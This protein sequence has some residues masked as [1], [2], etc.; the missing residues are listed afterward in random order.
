MLPVM[1]IG[2]AVATVVVQQ[3]T[4][5][6]PTKT[7]VTTPRLST[8]DSDNPGTANP[9]PIPAASFNYSYWM[10]LF[11]TITNI[12]DATLLNN[13]KFYSDGTIGWTLGS[14][15]ELRMGARDSGDFGLPGASYEQATG[16][17]GTSG[18]DLEASHTYYSGQTNKSDPVSGK[19]SGSPAT[20]D[21]GDHTIAEAFKGVILQAKVD[22]DAT[23]GAQT[24]EQLNF[25]YDEV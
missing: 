25:S 17:P 15:G 8:S 21:S 13:H 1:P 2:W 12:N 7:T 10:S 23:R 22:T 4:G 6:G 9:I 3:W 5:A 19:T 24:A 20:I 16:T 14:S 18:D 11:L